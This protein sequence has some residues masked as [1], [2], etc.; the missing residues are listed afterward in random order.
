M[1][2]LPFIQAT[3]DFAA[4]LL[5][6]QESDCAP[7][8]CYIRAKHQAFVCPA[9]WEP[10]NDTRIPPVCFLKLFRV[11]LDDF[12]WLC[13]SLRQEL[14]QD[15]QRRGDPLTAK[16]QVAVGLYRLGHLSS[17]VSISHVFNIGKETADKAL[18]CFVLAVLTA[19]RLVSV[20]LKQWD[21]IS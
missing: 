8:H 10:W 13:D 5:L 2:P 14:Q 20:R 17:F 6:A 21:A 19:L 3:S 4:L 9:C 16:A 18:A 7:Q 15:P 11:T 12:Q 1:L